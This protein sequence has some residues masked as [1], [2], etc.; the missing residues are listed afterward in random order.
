MA[1]E[2]AHIFESF[3]SVMELLRDEKF[4]DL[5]VNYERAKKHFVVGYA[6]EDAVSSE[7]LFAREG[8]VLKPESYLAAFSKFVKENE[9]AID[10][11]SIFEPTKELEHC[12][13]ERTE[14]EVERKYFL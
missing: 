8:S 9:T 3:S 5:L 14:K 4:Q 13:I 7:I 11:I 1:K 2:L 6:V 10:A 12:C